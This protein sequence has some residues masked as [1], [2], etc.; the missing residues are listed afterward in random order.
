[1]RTRVVEARRAADADA[2]RRQL[3]V[4]VAAPADADARRTLHRQP[5]RAALAAF[6]PGGGKSEVPVVT[7][8]HVRRHQRQAQKQRKQSEN[9]HKHQH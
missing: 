6:V 5:A 4:G 9:A 1:M 3:A 2:T 8:T 7:D